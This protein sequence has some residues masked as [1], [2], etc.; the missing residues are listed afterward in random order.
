MAQ[1]IQYDE[2]LPINF[3]MVKE[4]FVD[5]LVAEKFL[6][7]EQG[8]MI[9][10]NY[11]VTVVRKNWLGRMVDSLLWGKDSK[12]EFKLVVVKVIFPTK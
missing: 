10:K 4:G 9:K 7:P 6:T 2:G 12:D 3:N 1:I 8:E 11:S 5:A